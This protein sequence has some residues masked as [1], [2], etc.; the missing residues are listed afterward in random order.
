[1]NY[2]FIFLFVS[3]CVYVEYHVNYQ[4]PSVGHH[5]TTWMDFFSG[6]IKL[7]GLWKLSMVPVN[8]FKAKLLL[9]ADQNTPPTLVIV[10]AL[11]HL[12][13]RSFSFQ[14]AAVQIPQRSQPSSQTSINKRTTQRTVQCHITTWTKWLQITAHAHL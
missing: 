2:T 6:L 12:S 7:Q 9:L 14:C 3:E 11:G 8:Y 1:M 10:H 13:K 5:S 4:T